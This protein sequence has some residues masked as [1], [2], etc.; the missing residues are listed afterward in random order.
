MLIS[1]PTL[2]YH[3]VGTTTTAMSSTKNKMDATHAHPYYSPSSPPPAPVVHH[4]EEDELAVMK[5]TESLHEEVDTHTKYVCS[6]KLDGDLK[7]QQLL[8]LL[9]ILNRL[10]LLIPSTNH[11][12][13]INVNHVGID[14]RVACW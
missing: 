13:L 6:Y 8:L 5:I 9:T 2:T 3:T 7:Q 12:M 4:I 11:T 10:H 14:P 1:I